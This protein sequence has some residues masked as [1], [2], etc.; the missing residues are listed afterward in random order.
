MVLDRI[1]I[2]GVLTGHID[3]ED[4]RASSGTLIAVVIKYLAPSFF[5]Y[6]CLVYRFSSGRISWKA[7]AISGAVVFFAGLSLGAKTGAIFTIL[8]GI[9]ALFLNGM[10]M[11]TLAFLG[12]AGVVTIVG[13][14][15]TFDR[16]HRGDL[17]ATLQ[18]VADRAFILEA[19][20]P[21]KIIRRAADGTLGVDYLPTLAVVATNAVL[22]RTV[23]E[24]T[25]YRYSFPGVVSAEMYPRRIPNINSGRWNHTPDVMVEGVVAFGF[26]NFWLMA[27]IMVGIGW[28]LNNAIRSAVQA[29]NM[30][31]ASVVLT[32]FV[33]AYLAWINSAGV[34]SLIHPLVLGSLFIAWAMLRS[35][36]VPVRF[37]WRKSPLAVD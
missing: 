18:Y 35:I 14:G 7:V 6:I 33:F 30:A 20:P 21:Y 3:K 34:A 2:V 31:F 9:L 16:F 10:R 24:G 15:M 25:L 27:F 32:Y 11:R 8:P 5:A 19:E 36:P 17:G 22:R 26:Y 28:M 23:Q 13:A 29:G 4:I 37:L 1:D 12:M